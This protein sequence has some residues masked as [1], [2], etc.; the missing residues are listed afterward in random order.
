MLQLSIAKPTEPLRKLKVT[1]FAR[2][3]WRVGNGMGMISPFR[4]SSQVFESQMFTNVFS[5]I[6]P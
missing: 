2:N 5:A 4:T 6:N 1:S 3:Q